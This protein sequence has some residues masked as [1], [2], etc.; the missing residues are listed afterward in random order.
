M[1][2]VYG[3]KLEYLQKTHQPQG[4]YTPVGSTQKGWEENLRPSCCEATAWTTAVPWRP[5]CPYI[6]VTSNWNTNHRPEI[7]FYIPKC[8]LTCIVP[9]VSLSEPSSYTQ[10]HRWLCSQ[11]WPRRCWPDRRLR[12]YSRW[13]GSHSCQRQLDKDSKCSQWLPLYD[14]LTPL[15]CV[16]THL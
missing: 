14:H 2:L 7:S 5:Y 6:H 9:A 16:H 3:K 12:W 13:S 8:S 10:S 4:E 11:V 15:T 1:V